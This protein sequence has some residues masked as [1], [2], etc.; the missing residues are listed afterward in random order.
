[1]ENNPATRGNMDTDRLSMLIY[2]EQPQ[3]QPPDHL[4]TNYA[5]GLKK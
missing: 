5:S 4:F 1:M 3:Q 2:G